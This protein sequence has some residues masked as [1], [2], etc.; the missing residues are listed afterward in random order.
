MGEDFHHRL[1]QG[2]RDIAEREPDRC[3]VLDAEGSVANVHRDILAAI[4]D[5]LKV[6]LL[7]A[8]PAEEA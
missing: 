2:F 4:T 1:R 6:D 7:P 8:Q 3:A 5:R